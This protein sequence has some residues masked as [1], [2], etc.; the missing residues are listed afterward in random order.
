M[1]SLKGPITSALV[2]FALSATALA[3]ER[4]KGQ[5]GDHSKGLRS[6]GSDLHPRQVK[7]RSVMQVDLATRND[8]T[9]SAEKAK[10]IFTLVGHTGEGKEIRRLPSDDI[11]RSLTATKP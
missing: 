3:G 9:L 5:T 8:A 7:S 6:M 4:T 10:Q 2:I 11:V 1:T